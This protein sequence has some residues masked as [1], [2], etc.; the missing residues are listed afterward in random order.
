MAEAS[1]HNVIQDMRIDEHERRVSALEESTQAMLEAQAGMMAQMELTNG[2]LKQGFD[3]MKKLSLGI[4]GALSV[5][6]G[7]SQMVM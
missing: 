5:V 3:L 4:I 7:G 1:K 6:M 2:L